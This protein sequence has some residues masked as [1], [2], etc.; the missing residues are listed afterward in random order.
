MTT[1][2]FNLNSLVEKAEQAIPKSENDYYEDGILFCG[3]CRTPKETIIKHLGTSRKVRCVCN[4]AKEEAEKADREIHLQNYKIHIEEMRLRG[5]PDEYY[6]SMRFEN[7]DDS[8]SPV[9]KKCR[10]YVE[11]WDKMYASN[12]GM[13]F[14]GNAGTGKSFLAACIANKIIDMGFSVIMTSFPKILAM[15]F[16]EFEDFLN[17]IPS[18]PLMIIDDVGAES[19]RDYASERMYAV[20]DCRY[21]SHK[22]LIITTNLSPSE[23][24]KPSRIDLT[25]VYERISEM[26]GSFP[27]ELVGDSRRKK[28]ARNKWEEAKRILG[29]D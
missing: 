25:R 3:T 2:D 28:I 22:P 17:K 16:K 15:D 11:N 21:T 12:F 26:C 4:C 20:V 24:K 13:M 9:S 19:N 6:R 7:D 27:L 10:K 8:E 5:I 14:Y 23:I 29:E 18:Y 1:N